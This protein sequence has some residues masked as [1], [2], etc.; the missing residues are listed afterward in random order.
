MSAT[1]HKLFAPT[2]STTRGKPVL[3]GGDPKN[4][5]RILYTTGSSVVNRSLKDPSDAYLYQEHS[6]E[7]TVARYSP[8]GFYI[9]SADKS[10]RVRLWDTVNAEHILKAEYE[11]IGGP[12]LD[13][14]WDSESKRILAVG[15]GRGVYAKAILADGGNSVGEISGHSKVITTGD[16]KPS[17]PFRAVTGSEDLKVNWYPGPPFKYALS[18]KDHTRYINCIRFSPDGNKF[19]TVGSDKKG[20]IYEA[21]E[22]AKLLEIKEDHAGSIMAVSWS[23]DSKKFLTAS[24]DKTCKIWDA[25]TGQPLTTFKF[26]DNVDH[27]QLGCLWQGNHLV[28][29]SLNGDINFLDASN[30][31]QPAKVQHGHNK[32]I[33]ALAY[34]DGKL[35][36]GD[37]EAKVIEWKITDGTTQTF[38]G[39][40][41]KNQVSQMKIL[42]DHIVTASM[43]DS[44]KI[45]P[46]SSRVW[47]TSIGI[48]SVVSGVAVGKKSSDLVV[49]SSL[50]SVSVIRGGKLV[51]KVDIKYQA[52][53]IAISPNETE[54]AV[55]GSDFKIYLHKLEGD[56][57]T[58]TKVLE[59]HRGAVTALDY[60]PDGK[61]LGAADGNREVVVWENGEPKITGWVFH[62]AKVNALAWA[63]DSTHLAT[64]A[65]DSNLIVWDVKDTS[66]R[67]EIKRAHA[68]GGNDLVWIDNNTIASVG[69]D[70]ALKIW[71]IKF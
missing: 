62:T 45:T 16:I 37:Y 66:K 27:Q 34:K 50:Q 47:G 17:R 8:S 5:D 22:A 4:K 57:L 39:D 68:L 59:R 63:P 46:I 60:S 58:Q 51:S 19:V 42:G 26:T 3:V 41:H 25:E 70:C 71:N 9:A 49:V 31:S 28:S 7:C 35:Y 18:I 6:F 20:F 36:T 33:T 21:K 30:P 40:K 29:I 43:D 55:G 14:A 11:V 2:P 24:A 12:I 38:S 53:S 56:K 13:L 64:V 65:L 48:G 54:V 15:E 44:V 32:F 69:Q 10:G 1:L 61:H 67:V 23:D 52:T